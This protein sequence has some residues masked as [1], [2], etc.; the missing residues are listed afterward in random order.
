M[1]KMNVMRPSGGGGRR[2]QA[3]VQETMQ[4]VLWSI[5]TLVVVLMMV[6]AIAVS[7]V[8][9]G[10]IRCPLK[11]L[12]YDA[13]RLVQLGAALAATRRERIDRASFAEEPPP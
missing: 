10:K 3:H 4:T 8:A 13:V 1:G 6:F 2:K 7:A 9:V 11:M 12:R 5:Q